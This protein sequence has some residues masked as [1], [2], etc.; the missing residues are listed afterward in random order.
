M[1]LIYTL[2]LFAFIKELF[3]LFILISI[4]NVK[5][6]AIVMAPIMIILALVESKN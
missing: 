2:D 6:L 4:N 1:E 5:I 3:K